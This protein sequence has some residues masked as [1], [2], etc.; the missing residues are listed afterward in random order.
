VVIATFLSTLAAT[1]GR[2][3]RA[4]VAAALGFAEVRL[5]GVMTGIRRVLNVEGFAVVM[6][7]ESTGTVTINQ[8]LLVRQFGLDEKGASAT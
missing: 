5:R 3:A 7:D 8:A 2:A 4:T 6:E 1:Q